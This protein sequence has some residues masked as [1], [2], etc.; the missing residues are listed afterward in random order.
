M[1]LHQ[2]NP[3]WS[4]SFP[5][6]LR[7]SKLF[8]GSIQDRL[9]CC[10]LNKPNRRGGLGGQHDGWVQTT[11]GYMA[12]LHQLTWVSLPCDRQTCGRRCIQRPVQSTIHGEHNHN[13]PT[14]NNTCLNFA[15]CLS[16]T[17]RQKGK[18]DLIN[19]WLAAVTISSNM[20][21]FFE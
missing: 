15:L 12:H 20:M 3:L 21:H 9:P 17:V 14:C 11:G 4:K 19:I 10:E 18:C 5:W 16:V 2:T 8:Y 13:K 1:H 6:H 7:I